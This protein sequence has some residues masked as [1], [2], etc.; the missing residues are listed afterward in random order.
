MFRSVGVA[1][2]AT[3]K[4]TE[5]VRIKST[6]LEGAGLD[7]FERGPFN[8]HD[9]DSEQPLQPHGPARKDLD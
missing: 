6:R 3:S 1:K 5:R 7:L 9:A 4:L 8:L 2:L